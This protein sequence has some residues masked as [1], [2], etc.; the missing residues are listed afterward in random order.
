V[1]DIAWNAQQLVRHRHERMS[2]RGKLQ[3]VTIV[4]LA[5]ELWGF[6]WAVGQHVETESAR[7]RTAS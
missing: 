5:R 7:S 4:A 1:I 6:I 2:A 3:D